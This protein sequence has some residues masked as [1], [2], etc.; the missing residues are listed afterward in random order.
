MTTRNVD[1]VVAKYKEDISWTTLLKDNVIVYDKSENPLEASI[2]LPNV[3][4]EAHTYLYHIVKNYNNLADITIFLQGK[5]YDHTYK[6]RNP[7]NE[8][9]AEYINKLEFPVEY[10]GFLQ[11]PQDWDTPYQDLEIMSV[12]VN[13]RNIFKDK[14][15]LSQ[16]FSRGAQYIVPKENILAKPFEFYEKL[17]SISD[18]N[19]QFIN[20]ASGKLCPWCFE[21]IWPLIFDPKYEINPS[22]LSKA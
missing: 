20:D 12:I 17:L 10:Q 2:R 1:I 11:T 6:Y 19:V 21:R 13:G 5:P 18:T 3:G 15:G 14:I 22:F 7:T 8:V 9:C 16:K 4:R